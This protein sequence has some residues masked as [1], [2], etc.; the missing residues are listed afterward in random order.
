MYAI[1]T[2]HVRFD[3]TL[4]YSFKP[5]ILKYVGSIEEKISVHELYHLRTFIRS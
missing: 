5:F 4:L 3:Q 2:T 1:D